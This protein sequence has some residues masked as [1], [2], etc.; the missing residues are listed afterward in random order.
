MEIKLFK[1]LVTAM[2]LVSAGGC[3]TSIKNATTMQQDNVELQ[4]MVVK[5]QQIRLIEN[6][7][8]NLESVDKV[9][10]QKVMELLANGLIKT[11]KDKLSAALILQHTSLS[12][13]NDELK[14]NSIENYWLAYELSKSAFE[15]GEKGAGYYVAITLDRYLLYTLGMQKYGTQRV[16]DD[17]T[18]EEIWA[19][20]DS[21]TTDKERE[22]Y[23]VPALDSLL[24]R[25][26]MKPYQAK[27][28]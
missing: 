2:L 8:F 25:Y 28:K 27:S 15:S 1:Y 4:Q 12:Y 14:S 9:H 6:R 3:A 23:G 19:P 10:R 26:K 17:K 5:D 18:E 24:R 21:L 7:E 13:C 20:I 22:I 16:I 11:N